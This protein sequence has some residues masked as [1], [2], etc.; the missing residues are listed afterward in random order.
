MCKN[1]INTLV[2][3]ALIRNINYHSFF[4]T[5]CIYYTDI[6]FFKYPIET[7]QSNCQFICA[8]YF[9]NLFFSM[10]VGGGRGESECGSAQKY[11]CAWRSYG[12][13]SRYW[14]SLWRTAILWFKINAFRFLSSR[15]L[16]VKRNQSLEPNPAMVSPYQCYLNNNVITSITICL[17]FTNNREL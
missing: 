8:R 3:Y 6:K 15:V 9:E 12:S 5:P 1:K 17:Y 13:S 10:N 2:I 4:S 14:S 7:V 11:V 16:I